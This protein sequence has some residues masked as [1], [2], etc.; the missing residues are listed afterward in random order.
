MAHVV[1]GT[2]ILRRGGIPEP[3][4]EFAYTHHGTSVIEFFWHRCV[5]RGNP[6][7][8]GEDAFR[9]PGMRPRTKETAILMLIDSIEAAARTIDPPTRESFEEM[10]TRIAFVKLKQGQLDES[11]LTVEDLRV[12]TTSLVD[13]LVSVHHKRVRYPWQDREGTGRA[14]VP[15]PGPATEEDV[16]RARTK[17]GETTVAPDPE[18]T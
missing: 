6:K 13:T 14:Q 7:E 10:V 5:E 12:L 16:R 15:V 4:V 1:E 11:G 9:Y 8:L 18:E 3:V 2:N 17:T